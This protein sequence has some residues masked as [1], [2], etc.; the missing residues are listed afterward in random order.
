MKVEIIPFVGM[1]TMSDFKLSTRLEIC[2]NGLDVN[3]WVLLGSCYQYY[4]DIRRTA[5]PEDKFST[6][7]AQARHVFFT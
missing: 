3:W 4:C 6:I 1:S 5:T 2:E 7:R